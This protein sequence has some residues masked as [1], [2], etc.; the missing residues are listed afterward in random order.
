[1][2]ESGGKIICEQAYALGKMLDSS[3]WHGLLRNGITPSDIDLPAVPLCFDNNGSIIFCELATSFDDW[4]AL[5]V[6]KQ[7]QYLLYRNII[8]NMRIPCCAVLCKH[9]VTPEMN[10]SIDTLRDIERFHVMIWDSG[11]VL[12]PIYDGKRWSGF[13]TRWVN[14]ADGPRVIRRHIIAE[15]TGAESKSF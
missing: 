4:N 2:S 15:S 10:R 11:A 13:V 14:R 7:G 1:M 9:A 5:S 12:S 8:M 3:G 6:A